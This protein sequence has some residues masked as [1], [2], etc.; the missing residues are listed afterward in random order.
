LGGHE[1]GRETEIKRDAH[2]RTYIHTASAAA[3]DAASASFWA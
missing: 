2:T 1:K 3:A